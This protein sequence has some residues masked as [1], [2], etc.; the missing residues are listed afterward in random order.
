MGSF[1]SQ[2]SQQNYTSTGEKI[3]NSLDFGRRKQIF[4]NDQQFPWILIFKI[5]RNFGIPLFGT[6]P[7]LY[8]WHFPWNKPSSYGGT[9]HCQVAGRALVA[10]LWAIFLPVS[11]VAVLARVALIIAYRLALPR[12]ARDPC[13]QFVVGFMRKKQ[14]FAE[15]FHR[16]EPVFCLFV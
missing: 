11:T 7:Q 5:D 14:D 1:R 16:E 3:Y 4:A 6:T 15:W 9:P 2:R 10:A 13:A 12:C 8:L